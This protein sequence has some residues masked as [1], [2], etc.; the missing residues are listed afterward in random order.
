MLIQPGAGGCLCVCVCERWEG[1]RLMISSPPPPP[2]LP[3]LSRPLHASASGQEGEKDEDP[4]DRLRHP[5]GRV[6]PQ[7]QPRAHAAG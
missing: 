4:V 5:E 7:A 3:R 6:D 1:G 2:L